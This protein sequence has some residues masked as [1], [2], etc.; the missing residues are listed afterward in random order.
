MQYQ[1]QSNSVHNKSIGKVKVS[2]KNYFSRI[3]KISPLL[4][5]PENVFYYSNL[6]TNIC[7]SSVKYLKVYKVSI[8]N[9]NMLK[10]VICNM[11]KK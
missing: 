5:N 1:T 3:N 8:Y 11:C 10:I 6:N 9:S 2:E 7:Y 4:K